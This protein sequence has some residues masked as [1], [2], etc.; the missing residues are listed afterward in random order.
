MDLKGDNCD[1]GC[2]TLQA[3]LSR[4]FPEI[5]FIRTATSF[6]IEYQNQKYQLN[7]GGLWWGDFTVKT[8]KSA[9]RFVDLPG[10]YSLNLFFVNRSNVQYVIQ[11]MQLGKQTKIQGKSANDRI[12]TIARREQ[13]GEQ[14]ILIVGLGDFLIQAGAILWGQNG[15]FVASWW[16]LLGLVIA[17]ISNKAVS[18]Y[19]RSHVP[20]PQSSGLYS[21]TPLKEKK[22]HPWRA[23]LHQWKHQALQKVKASPRL[24]SLEAVPQ[25]MGTGDFKN[26]KIA[27]FLSQK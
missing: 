8:N 24:E 10:F 15:L 19:L 22:S 6:I 9:P 2:K 1:K 3:E 5:K 12:M 7:L 21:E 23:K 17:W 26:Q 11:K 4:L 20:F 27:E 13:I 18:A 25:A 14:I 16:I